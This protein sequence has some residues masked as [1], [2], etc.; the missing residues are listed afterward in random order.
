MKNNILLII[1]VTIVVGVIGFFSG[2]Q[3]Q[4]SRQ[5][6]FL[7]GQFRSGING[8]A[9]RNFQ[10]TRAINGEIISQGANSVTVKLADGSTRI[11]I[12]ADNTRIDKATQASTADLKTGERIVVFGVVNSDGSVTAQTIAIGGNL[13]RN[14][15]GM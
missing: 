13:L 12:L 2:I 10:G 5:T 15:S 3:Y 6:N 7:Q 1:I 8:Q 4:K 9:R 11:I 14:P